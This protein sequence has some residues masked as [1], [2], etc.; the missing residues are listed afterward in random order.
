MATS[1]D[2]AIVLAL[3]ISGSVSAGEFALQKNGYED[4]FRELDV[5]S[6]IESKTFGKVIVCMVMWASHPTTVIDW[7]VL[8][9]SATCNA[10]ADV[11]AATT[12]PSSGVVGNQTAIGDAINFSVDKINDLTGFYTATSKVIDISGDGENNFGSS[13]TDER[14]AAGQQNI[15]INGVVIGDIVLKAYYED[16]VIIGD[17]SFVYQATTFSGFNTAILTKILAE[18]ASSC[19]AD[20]FVLAEEDGSTLNASSYTPYTSGGILRKSETSFTSLTH[21][22]G[23][24]VGVLGDGE[25][26]GTYVV[27]SAS[28]NLAS[29][30]GIVHIGLPYTSDL[31]TLNM[32]LI[33]NGVSI[34]GEH[35]KVNNVTFRLLNSRGG[36]IGPDEDNVYEAFTSDNLSAAYQLMDT[37]GDENANAKLYNVDI[38]VPLGSEYRKGGRIFYRQTDPLPITINAI[39]PEIS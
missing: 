8:S 1:V 11:I 33:N 39:V 2:L 36:Y 23:M 7:T 30:A 9:D 13:V 17:E 10:F 31:E 18:L 6:A 27:S 14:D 3:D 12:R 28:I 15:N 24:V 34:Q 29:S 19:A 37:I 25:Y 21:L 16:N 35:V 26:L 4:A 22:N 38:R 5:I 32:D 20:A